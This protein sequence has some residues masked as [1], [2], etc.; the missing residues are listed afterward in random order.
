MRCRDSWWRSL[1]SQR[2]ARCGYLCG[3][4]G[5]R[6]IAVAGFE[7][8]LRTACI[9][10]EIVIESAVGHAVGAGRPSVHAIMH[11]MVFLHL[12]RRA[13]RAFV[14]I[15]DLICH[16]AGLQREV[17]PDSRK[18][19]EGAAA[20]GSTLI[21]DAGQIT[22]VFVLARISA[23]SPN[24]STEAI[25]TDPKRQGQTSLRSEYDLQ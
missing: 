22:Q 5:Y 7:F 8:G 21:S 3:N 17:Q 6:R 20:P 24:S 1:A 14:V 16:R 12:G 2:L 4:N 9:V 11:A 25:G 18:Q 19:S 13:V 23:L 10:T 15:F